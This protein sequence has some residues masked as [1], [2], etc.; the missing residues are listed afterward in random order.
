MCF[1]IKFYIKIIVELLI[2]VIHVIKKQE[3]LLRIYRNVWVN[4]SALL[5]AVIT[6]MDRKL[7]W[8]ALCVEIIKKAEKII[9]KKIEFFICVF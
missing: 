3:L 2:F 4:K 8:V 1:Y 6:R 7:P 9:D 5:K